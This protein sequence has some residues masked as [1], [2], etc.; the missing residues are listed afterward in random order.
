MRVIVSAPE[1]SIDQALRFAAEDG[2]F[3]TDSEPRPQDLCSALFRDPAALGVIRA[4]NSAFASIT[5]RD[6]RQADVRN[7][8][9]VLLDGAEA[10]H[11]AI[12]LILKC[13]ADDVQPAPIDRIE[14]V[15]RLSALSRR[16]PYHDHLMICMPG[17]TFEAET[18]HLANTGG[19]KQH[20]TPIETKLLMALALDPSRTFSKDDIMDRL[21]DGEN[22]PERKIVDVLVCKLRRKLAEMNGG[23][24]VVETVWGRGYR[25]VPEG[26][27]PR[28]TATRKRVL[29]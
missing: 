21:Y 3:E 27:E 24:D 19:K 13:G 18:G 17:C 28:F 9:F 5:C 10:H 6:F 15:A 26:F 20:L 14:F 25:F 22:E 4:P 2:G 8:L 11:S 29:R 7:L 23:L 16:G 1:P 12:A